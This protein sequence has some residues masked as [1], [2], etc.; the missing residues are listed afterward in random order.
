MIKIEQALAR[1]KEQGKKVLKKE[2]AAK[3]WPDSSA[4]AQQVN[5]TALCSGKTTKINHEW[6]K[7]ICE[8]TG[9]TADFLFG[10]T[11]E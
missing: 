8:M 10:I 9:C 4:I 2:L 1:S 6:V 3:L 5:M 7:I 11:K